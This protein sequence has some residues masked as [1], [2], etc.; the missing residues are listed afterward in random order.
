MYGTV[1]KFR[2]KPGAEQRLREFDEM[3]WGLAMPGYIGEFAL[4]SDANPNEWYMLVIFESKE[5]YFANADSPE[6]DARYR[7]LLELLDAE[8]EWHD[9]EIVYAWQ[10]QMNLK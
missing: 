3:E 7:Q 1:A 9:G 4:R 2:V 8:P 6:Q 10:A 5:A